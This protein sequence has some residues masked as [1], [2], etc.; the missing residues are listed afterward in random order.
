MQSTSNGSIAGVLGIPKM[1]ATAAINST[2]KLSI[3]NHTKVKRD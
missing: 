2:V 1:P 3:Q